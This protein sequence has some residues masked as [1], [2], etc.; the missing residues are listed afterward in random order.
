[1]RSYPAGPSGGSAG[2]TV[3]GM[4]R[5]WWSRPLVV[6]V[7]LAACS[8]D[9]PADTAAPTAAVTAET[10]LAEAAEAMAAVDS[11][12]F[13]LTRSG[14]EAHLDDGETI[15]FNSADGR[16]AAP[17]SADAVVEVA[18]AGFTTEVGAVAVD[19]EIWLTNPVTGAWE[20]APEELTFNPA[21]LF[22]PEVG[23]RAL[24]ANGLSD[25]ELVE[26]SADR[27]RITGTAAA[28]RVD[29]L[30]GGLVEAAAPIEVVIDTDTGL[31]DEVSFDVEVADGT[32][33]WQVVLVDYGTEV[34]VTVPP[35]D[36]G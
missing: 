16:F 25:V 34:M 6:L 19:G 2:R 7:L 3:G 5:S 17:D 30:T 29:V 15:T 26:T 28:E 31:L 12:R 33:M 14:A 22:D 1:M 27:H 24:L 20:A 35:L 4:R 23:W 10:I 32:T 18:I 36:G 8:G 13:E 21:T 9:D 11:V